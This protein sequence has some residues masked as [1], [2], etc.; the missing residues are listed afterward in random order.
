MVQSR[1]NLA[2]FVGQLPRPFGR[3]DPLGDGISE[4]LPNDP[5][6]HD[7]PSRQ[8][9]HVGGAQRCQVVNLD[10]PRA[11]G[12]GLVEAHGLNASPAEED[13]GTREPEGR[14]GM[15]GLGQNPSD[16]LCGG[17]HFVEVIAIGRPGGT[18]VVHSIPGEA[19]KRLPL[20]GNGHEAPIGELPGEVDHEVDALE[21]HHA[22]L[23]VPGQFGGGAVDPGASGIDDQLGAN[24][25][26]GVGCE[27]IAQREFPLVAD[28][29]RS[30]AFRIISGHRAELASVFQGVDDHP[31]RGYEL[32]VAKDGDPLELVP[33]AKPPDIRHLVHGLLAVAHIVQRVSAWP[34]DLQQLKTGVHLPAGVGAILVDRNAELEGPDQFPHRLGHLVLR[35][36]GLPGVL[37]GD[38]EAQGVAGKFPRGSARREMAKSAVQD[39]TGATGGALGKI[40]FVNHENAIAAGRELLGRAGSVDAPADHDHIEGVLGEGLE[41]GTAH[42]NLFVAFRMLA[43][44][45]CVGRINALYAQ[46][47]RPF[48]TAK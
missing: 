2:C 24:G 47:H 28:A 26:G 8:Y 18:D 30:S 16:F 11:L 19:I 38:Q 46:V 4:I 21:A 29:G 39:T 43:R 48:T 3:V 14:K 20:A 27:G 15:I 7:G 22:L 1:G 40:S 25:D 6:G 41:G 33:I 13:I 5:K 37:A 32:V 42:E 10:C 12:L 9:E 34:Q 17:G 31:L 44:S 45:R 23:L 35:D 36:H